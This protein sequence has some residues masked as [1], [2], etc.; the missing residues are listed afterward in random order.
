VNILTGAFLVNGAPVGR[1]PAAIIDSAVYA[2]TFGS[3]V[4]EVQPAERQGLYITKSELNGSR[5]TFE[6]QRSSTSASSSSSISATAAVVIICER[7]S[8]GGESLQ[9]IPH[10][11]FQGDLPQQLVDDY[12]HWLRKDVNSSSSDSSSSSSYTVLFRLV[13]ADA[14]AFSSLSCEA[15]PYELQLQ[16]RSDGS[17]VNT[18]RC[19]R[20]G[21]LFVDV[22]SSTFEQLYSSVFSRLEQR[23]RVH[24]M[25]SVT[26]AVAATAVAA[27]A[28]AA[29]AT[30]AAAVAAVAAAAA[31][32][33]AVAAAV[34]AEG[35]ALSVDSSVNSSSG[36]TND[37]S[38]SSDSSN[39]SDWTSTYSETE[40]AVAA[41][42]A[43]AHGAEL[44]D[45]HC[46]W[47]YHHK[48]SFTVHKSQIF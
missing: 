26:A 18:V 34:V 23:L 39:N 37:S 9:L 12:S 24:V 27:T 44:R 43:A 2:R 7:R 48:V 15:V 21:A 31:A 33:A 1:L 5:F 10:T 32:V 20:T 40:R 6:L 11:H 8:G 42:C 47:C 45:R 29:T 19:A 28:A 13:R 36:I 46:C 30:A 4:F 41:C 16:Q 35:D 17:F 14:A 22:R 25:V 38:S 3:T